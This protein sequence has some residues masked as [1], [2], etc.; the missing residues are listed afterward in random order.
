MVNLALD[1]GNTHIK[2]ASFTGADLT[3][4]HQFET[5]GE[6]L[7]NEAYILKHQSIIITSVTN[8]HLAFMEMFSS[9]LFCLLFSS[10]TPLPIKNDYKTAST[11]GSDRLAASVG[12]FTLYPNCDVLTIDCGTCIKYNFVTQANEYIGGAISPG[13]KMRLKALN[14]FTDKL[15]LIKFNESFNQLIGQTTEESILSGVINGATKEIDGIINDY[16]LVYPNLITVITGG[17]G[18]FFVKRLKNS[19]FAHPN[20]VLI[21]LNKILLNHLEKN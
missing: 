16:K 4:F 10:N 3:E 12:A 6:L 1:F 5:I 21:G 14:T 9:Q 2:A 7:K 17:H 11:L 8:V 15:P 13:I 19:I 20:L 18:N